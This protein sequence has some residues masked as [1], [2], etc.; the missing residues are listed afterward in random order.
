MIVGVTCIDVCPVTG[1]M[2]RSHIMG[3]TQGPFFLEAEGKVLTK[4]VF[5]H[6]I[7]TCYK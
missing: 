3:S 6:R 4:S 7:G 5:V 2:S 1:F